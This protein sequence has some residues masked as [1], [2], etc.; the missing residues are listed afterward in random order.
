MNDPL[1]GDNAKLEVSAGAGL[2]KSD[3]L[4]LTEELASR[5]RVTVDWIRDA[6]K[7]KKLH[8]IRI[9]RRDWRWHWESVLE[10]LKRLA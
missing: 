6:V 8:P 1:H 4:L 5:L 10:D 9:S 7:A 3:R 2:P